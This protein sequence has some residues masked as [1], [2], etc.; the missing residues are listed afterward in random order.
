M[1]RI[2]YC[3]SGELGSK[4]TKHREQYNLGRIVTAGI[5]GKISRKMYCTW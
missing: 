5:I 2:E 4:L 1:Q 3:G